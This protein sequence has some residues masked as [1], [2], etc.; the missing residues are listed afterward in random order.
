MVNAAPKLSAGVRRILG[1]DFFAG[2]TEEALK[3][4][5]PGGLVV[6][7]AAPALVEMV[8]DEAYREALLRAD[9]VLTDSGF[10]VLIWNW[11][12]GDHLRRVSGLEYLKLLL[13]HPSLGQPDDVLWVMPS[14]AARDKNLAWLRSRGLNFSVEH[15]YLAPLY[16]RNQVEDPALV[17]LINERRPRHVIVGL[18]GG[19]Q[20]KLGLYLKRNCHYLPAIH[21]I[22]AAIGF[23][24][25]DQV[26]IPDW[27]D[28]W[29]LGWLLRCTS[30][31]RR[32]IPRYLRALRLA[33]MLIRYRERSPCAP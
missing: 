20:E 1:V 22:G 18:G 9:L 8:T 4:S 19:V 27:A 3:K 6:V 16:P 21:C 32:F 14:A 17:A 12:T 26:S 33:P 15:C 31:P 25:G 2:T 23:L 11:L 30:Q 5:L 29:F 28:R 10:M 24:S 7:P 13:D